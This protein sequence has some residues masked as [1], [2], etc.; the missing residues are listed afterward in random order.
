MS[1]TAIPD[2]LLGATIKSSLILL[3][4]LCAAA[5]LRRRSAALRHWVSEC[6]LRGACQ[7]EVH[8]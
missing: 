3:C 6:K 5:C 2:L 1:T 8:V 4:A 7:E